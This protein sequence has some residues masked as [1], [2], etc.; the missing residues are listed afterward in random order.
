MAIS[1]S[2]IREQ[3]HTIG[4]RYAI[5]AGHNVALG[6]EWHQHV[7]SRETK[8]GAIVGADKALSLFDADELEHGCCRG[9]EGSFAAR[10]EL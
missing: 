8:Q 3:R 10:F 2:L 6:M 1:P 9:G 5:V 4:S 7:A